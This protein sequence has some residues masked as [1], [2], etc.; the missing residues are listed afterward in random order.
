[1][2]YR[3]PFHV[4]KKTLKLGNKVYYYVTYDKFNKRKQ[5]STGC[6]TKTKLYIIH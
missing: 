1:M 2:R 3:A 4:F 6:K 5:Y